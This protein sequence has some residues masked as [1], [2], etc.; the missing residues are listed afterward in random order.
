MTCNPA[1]DAPC[2]AVTEPTMLTLDAT[3]QRLADAQLDA[4]LDLYAD[5]HD[6]LMAPWRTVIGDQA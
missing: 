5:Q 2:W 3:F 4:A 1:D 6:L